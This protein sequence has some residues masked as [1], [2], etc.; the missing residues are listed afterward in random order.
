[1]DMRTYGKWD[2][3]LDAIV[4]TL[5]GY[6]NAHAHLDRAN[7]MDSKY[8]AHMNLDPREVASFSLRVK[9]NSVGYLHTGLAYTSED[10][11][12]RMK[13]ELERMTTI[14]GVKEVTS[15]IDV[16]PDIRLRALEA[17]LKL[18]DDF[19]ER[20]KFQVGAYPVFGFKERPEE[21][22][23]RWELFKEAAE[24]ADFL[25]TLPDRDADGI[26]IDEHFRRVLQLGRDLDKE[27]HCHVDQDN[28]P[29]QNQTETLI[30]AVR[31]L[32]SPKK[33]SEPSVWAVH[34]ISPSC[35]PEEHFR[36]LVDG[37]L[38]YNIGV[39]SCPSAAISMRQL[40]NYV[41]PTHNSVARI[42]ELLEAGVYVKIG[43][44]NISDIFIPNGDGKIESELWSAASFCRF[45]RENI[46]A[47]VGS[48]TRLNDVDRE[49]IRREVLTAT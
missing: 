35:Y 6:E 21:K 14:L 41:T 26:G 15:F 28:T 49:Y 27:V 20:I 5:G 47:K 36:R 3:N 13:S 22:P 43:T 25:G 30:E 4:K 34:V 8:W 40:R 11:Y 1:M 19:A 7:T 12:A 39:I 9:Q 44:D 16:S 2:E 29:D 17:A 42:L 32:G 45:Y 33:D 37:L 31:W 18:K 38:K 48:G 24:M 46:W 10:L 23:T